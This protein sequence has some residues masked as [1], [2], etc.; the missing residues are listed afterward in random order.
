MRESFFVFAYDFV[1]VDHIALCHLP[2][3][4]ADRAELCELFI[5]QFGNV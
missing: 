2:E 5:C 1:Q 3:S 4:I